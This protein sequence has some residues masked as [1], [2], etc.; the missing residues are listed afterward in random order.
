MSELSIDVV[1]KFWHSFPDKMIYRVVSFI[2]GVE[3]WTFDENP[4]FEEIIETIGLE[5][6]DLGKVDMTKL[7][8]ELHFIQIAN[9]MH[10]SRALRFLHVIDAA[11][12]GAASRLLAHAEEITDSSEDDAGLFLRRNI[13][14]ERLR[15]LGRVFSEER[16]K[17]ILSALD[18]EES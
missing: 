6:E 11:H 18:T 12:P 1:Q 4:E 5:L 9:H 15:L 17:L 16:L 10:F 7:G 14:F 2:D 8:H 3:K 13:V